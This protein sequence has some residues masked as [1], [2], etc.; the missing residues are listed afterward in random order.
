MLMEHLADAEGDAD[1]LLALKCADLRGVHD[2]VN[3][4]EWL[5]SVG[6]PE[7]AIACAE[8]AAKLFPHPHD[9]PV[10]RDFLLA[11]YQRAGRSDAALRLAWEQF[12]EAPDGERYRALRNLVLAGD[13][14]PWPAWRDR[15]LAR[16]RAQTENTR[17]RAGNAPS[18]ARPDDSL[19]VEVLLE[20]NLVGEAWQ[21]AAS[22]GCRA[23]LWLRLAG[24]RERDHPED[25]IRVYR[26]QIDHA[27]AA[28]VPHGYGEAVELLMRA[29]TLSLRLQRGAEH[30][31]Y[32][33]A[34]R[35]THRKK[36]AF[37]RLLTAAG[38]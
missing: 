25:A 28:G 26:R 38:A 11:A 29:R 5:E 12:D 10:W 27:L 2:H 36:R 24:L 7:E 9:R 32:V 37:L 6:R 35:S 13:A 14:A 15:A 3:V 18:T 30:G 17:R 33:A 20:E 1:A 21:A 31:R 8:Q 34:L 22:G 16:T 4:A 19:L 23:D